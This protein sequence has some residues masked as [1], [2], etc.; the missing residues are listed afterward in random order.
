MLITFT[1]SGCLGMELGAPT[2]NDVTYVERNGRSG[3]LSSYTYSIEVSGKGKSFGSLHRPSTTPT[4][5][6]IS[7]Q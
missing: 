3:A 1:V 5:C 2:L 6:D 4:D 7:H